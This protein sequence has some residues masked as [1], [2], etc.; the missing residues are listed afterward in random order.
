[1]NLDE[2]YIYYITTIN[3]AIEKFIMSNNK[4]PMEII[5]P[6]RIFEFLKLYCENNSTKFDSSGNFTISGITVCSANDDDIKKGHLI[7]YS[8]NQQRHMSVDV[9]NYMIF[10]I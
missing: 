9:D 6:N 7:C 4:H 3:S 5:I 1:M 10:D 2:K 8:Y